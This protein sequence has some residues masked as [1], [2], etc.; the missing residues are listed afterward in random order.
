MQN[1]TTYIQN[2][3]LH[4]VGNKTRHVPAV[5]FSLTGK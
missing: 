1:E 4:S 3:D 2:Q 5:F